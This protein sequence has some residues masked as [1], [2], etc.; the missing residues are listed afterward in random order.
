MRTVA[1]YL[2]LPLRLE[3]M[4]LIVIFS[5]GMT[6]AE[7]LGVYG[8]LLFATLG[9]WFFKY[10]FMLLDHVIEGRRGAPV[11]SVE[12]ANPF[13]QR[14]M[15][16][17]L[18]LILF[19]SITAWSRP[20]IGDDGVMLLRALFLMLVPAMVATMSLTG[21][22]AQALNPVAVFGTV[23]R[24]PGAYIV[25]IAFIAAL[26]YMPITVVMGARD[27]LATLWQPQTFLPGGLTLAFGGTGILISLFGHLL[28]MYLWLAMFACVGGMIYEHRLELNVEPVES[29]ERSAARVSAAIERERDQV[30][31][32]IFAEIRGGAFANAG[33]SVRHII[34]TS[35]NPLEE[36]RWL[37]R[38]AN[39]VHTGLTDFVAQLLLSKLLTVKETG[40]CLSITKER[41][42]ANSKFR[43]TTAGE[44]LHLAQLACDAGESHIARSLLVDFELIF[45]N[46]PLTA[47]V[48]RMRAQLA[49]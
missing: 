21:E 45:P 5:I 6:F 47:N 16:L 19:Y 49:R 44:L 7:I 39:S 36:A 15:G 4:L 33:R 34:E 25:T 48:V 37:Y 41:L 46:D 24:I 35:S 3:P 42:A 20:L 26:W 32:R 31:D 8:V 30:M 9:S 40:E 1:K 12:M 28:F 43:P 2:S 23:A 17:L 18:L 14:P 38:R 27:S 29:P 11:L 13:E 22:F 10:G